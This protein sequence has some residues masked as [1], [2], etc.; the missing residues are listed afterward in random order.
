VGATPADATPRLLRRRRRARGA[1]REFVALPIADLRTPCLEPERGSDGRS[2]DGRLPEVSIVGSIDGEADR[3]ATA[4]RCPAARASTPCASSASF[5]PRRSRTVGRASG[6]GLA[7]SCVAW[8]STAAA[9]RR[10][11]KTNSRCPRH[12]N[13]SARTM[14][15]SSSSMRRWWSPLPPN[16]TGTSFGEGHRLRRRPPN[17]RP[18]SRARSTRQSAMMPSGRNTRKRRAQH[19]G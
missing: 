14:T 16:S 6:D 3:D 11:S 12:A 5:A 2:V 10:F 7:W 4:R 9:G 15:I 19:A 17:A 8:P 13:A 1:H 18:A